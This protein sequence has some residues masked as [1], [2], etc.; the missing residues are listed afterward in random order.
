MS[1]E[2]S[3]EIVDIISHHF[4]ISRA[5]VLPWIYTPATKVIQLAKIRR[6]VLASLLGYGVRRELISSPS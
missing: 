3:Q 5:L 4:V 6:F 2:V 1:T